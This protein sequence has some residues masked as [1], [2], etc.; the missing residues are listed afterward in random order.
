VAFLPIQQQ[1]RGSLACAALALTCLLHSP[2]AADWSAALPIF[3][4]CS[5]GTTPE[6]PVRWRAVGLM[7][8]FLRGQ[9]DVGEFIYDGALPAM[10]ATVYGLRS[11]AVDLLITDSDTY[12]LIG[13]HSSPTQCTSLGPRLR[14]P[15]GQWLGADAVCVGESPLADQ[16]VQWWHTTDFDPARYWVAKDTRLPWR[17]LFLRRSLNP[18]IIGDYAMTYFPAFVPLPETGL[19]ELRDFCAAKSGPY[20]GELPDVPTARDLIALRNNAAEE[21][22]AERIATLIPGLSHEACSQMKPIRWPDRYVTTA[23]V[24]PIQFNDIP[25]SALIYYDWSQTGTQLILPFQGRPPSL[26]GVISLKKNVGFRMRLPPKGNGTCA[27]V[28]PGLVRPDWMTVAS[29]ECQGVIEHNATLS[30]HANSQILACPIKAQGQRIMWNWY[31]TDG[32]PIMFTEAM[33]EGGGVMLV[34]YQDWLPGQTADPA[35]LELPKACAVSA[36]SAGSSSGGS[37][38]SNVS[39]SDCHTTP[40]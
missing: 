36:D 38:F 40:R 12:V 23:M 25:Y 32:R 35:D 7:M 21:E 13:P 16:T 29:C 3:G 18:A 1:N 14:V 37:T 6:L 34:D 33:P 10:R 20:S 30:P 11:G 39:C 8:P 22:R 24:T 15:A 17:S 2:A 31:T 19:S 28:L 9:I 27:A 5:P 26:Q 4:A